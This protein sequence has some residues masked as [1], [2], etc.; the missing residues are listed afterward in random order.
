MAYRSL[1]DHRIVLLGLPTTWQKRLVDVGVQT[2]QDKDIAWADYVF[3]S[4]MRIDNDLEVVL[5][6]LGTQLVAVRSAWRS[7]TFPPGAEAAGR[8]LGSL[9]RVRLRAGR[10][11]PHR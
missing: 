9:L 8:D 10:K 5:R 2:L 1:G 6:S 4:A 11:K 7:L 3:I